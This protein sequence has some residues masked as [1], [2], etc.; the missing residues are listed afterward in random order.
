MFEEIAQEIN[1]LYPG[2]SRETGSSRREALRV[3]L[4][5]GFAAAAGPVMSQTAIH[6]DM[7][8]LKGGT[9]T[10]VV[11]GFKVP[12]YWAAPE[13][14]TGLAVVLV[15]HEIFG[16]HEHIADVCRRFAKAGYLAIA[17]EFFARQGDIRQYTDIS[18]IMT[19][20]VPKVSDE[21][22]LADLDGALTWAAANGGDVTRAA[23]SGF[24][25]GGRIAWLF[26][27]HAPI[28]AAVAWYGR[29]VGSKSAMNPKNPVDLVDDLKAPV[30]GLYG[31]QDGGILVETV[32]E[33]KDKLQTGNANAK[34]SQIVIYQDAGHAFFA[35]YRASYRKQAAEDGW[36]RSI[37]WLKSKGAV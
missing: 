8:G 36:Q 4:G 5:A 15:V 32:D 27:A 20:I 11:N 19:E 28:K 1:S 31:A 2:S 9:T 24:C 7:T 30:L 35:D 21:Q 29:I 17:P 26:A 37:D 22:V 23:I 12:A 18:K 25:W 34:A 6:T 13:G 3:V 16:V 14:K 33:M 10:Y